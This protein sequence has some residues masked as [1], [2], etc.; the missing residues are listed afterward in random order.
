M[1]VTERPNGLGGKVECPLLL[2][3]M[4]FLLVRA[5]REPTET[6]GRRHRVARIIKKGRFVGKSFLLI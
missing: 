3:G 1:Q 4:E 2:S 6:G 5:L